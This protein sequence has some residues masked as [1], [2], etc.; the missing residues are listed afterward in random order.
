MSNLAKIKRT[1]K[2]RLLIRSLSDLFCTN[3]TVNAHKLYPN[4]YYKHFYFTKPLFDGIELI[5]KIERTSKKDAAELLMKAGISSYMGD[6]ISEYIHSE[7]VAREQNDAKVSRFI[8]F[9]KRYAREQSTDISKI[10]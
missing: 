4:E 3:R 5:A 7:H 8:M 2:P 10:I 1:I 9:L 6:K